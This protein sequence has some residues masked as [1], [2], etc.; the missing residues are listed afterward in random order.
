MIDSLDCATLYIGYID[1]QLLLGRIHTS[2]ETI[3][4]IMSSFCCYFSTVKKNYSVVY[5]IYLQ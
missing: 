1:R 2:R 3:G 4:F 5:M